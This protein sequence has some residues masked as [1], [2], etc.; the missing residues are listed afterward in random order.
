MAHSLAPGRY[1]FRAPDSKPDS[2]GRVHFTLL[3]WDDAIPLER[4][5]TKA[6]FRGQCFH[7]DPARYVAKGF[8][9]TAPEV[10]P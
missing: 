5:L 4:G 7:A 6:G 9:E 8:V 10:L 2:L 3:W 1:L